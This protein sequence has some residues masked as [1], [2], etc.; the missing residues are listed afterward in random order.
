MKPKYIGLPVDQRLVHLVTEW[1]RK[2]SE[3]KFYN[4]NALAI[5]IQ[6]IHVNVIPALDS[7]KSISEALECGFN[8]R[9]LDFMKKG[10]GV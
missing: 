1:D 2:Q 6:S 3:K 8:D 5:Y 4:H 7:G 9:L 10:M